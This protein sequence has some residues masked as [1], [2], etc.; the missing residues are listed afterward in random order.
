MLETRLQ[1]TG[2]LVQ[3]SVSGVEK[4]APGVHLPAFIWNQGIVPAISKKGAQGLP[5]QQV[6]PSEPSRGWENNSP[7]PQT[8]F[9]STQQDLPEKLHRFSSACGT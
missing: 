2:L 5:R 4:E 1:E 9:S 6:P 7:L 8:G 3:N